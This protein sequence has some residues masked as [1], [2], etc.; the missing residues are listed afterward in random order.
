MPLLGEGTVSEG[1]HSMNLGVHSFH[2][3]LLSALAERTRTSG[4]E[5][6]SQREDALV[7]PVAHTSSIRQTQGQSA[8]PDL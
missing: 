5:R 8:W 6:S 1:P 4:C 3:S 7:I 2:V